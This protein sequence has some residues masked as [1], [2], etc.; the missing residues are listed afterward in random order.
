[1]VISKIKTSKQVDRQRQNT[2]NRFRGFVHNERGESNMVL[3][4]GMADVVQPTP[5][6]LK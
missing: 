3:T 4:V 6:I 1:M 5:D 2:Q